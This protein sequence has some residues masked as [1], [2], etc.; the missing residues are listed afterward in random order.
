MTEYEETEPSE[1]KKINNQLQ[2]E[3]YILQLLIVLLMF[4]LSSLLSIQYQ[5]G[6]QVV[7]D[8]MEKV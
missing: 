1:T 2:S 3:I 7:L 6:L 5:G 4:I 8:Y